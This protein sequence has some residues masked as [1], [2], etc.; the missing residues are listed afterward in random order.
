MVTSHPF[1]GYIVSFLPDDLRFRKRRRDNLARALQWWLDKTSVPI[2]ILTSNW[3]PADVTLIGLDVDLSR[4]TVVELPPQPLILNRIAALETFYSSA[5]DWGVMLDDD[6]LL[7]DGPQHNRGPRLFV[8]MA[9]NGIAAYDGID[10]FFPINPQKIGFGPIYR[11]D[12][13][14]YLNHHV[15]KRNIDLKGSMF[16]VRNF[17]KQNKKIVLPDATFTLHGE[18]RYFALEAV[19]LGYSVMRCENIVLREFGSPSHFGAN[20]TQQMKIG[21]SHL[22]TMYQAQGLSMRPGSHLHDLSAFW[23]NCW[24][25]KPT[26]VVI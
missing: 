18:D 19:K 24:G 17:R 9:S 1:G 15:F 16:V 11:D 5:H 6:A 7:Y 12:P 3:K 25:S 4:V 23:R 2:T 20:R 26:Q 8:E 22:A 14:L 21:Y 13:N 10:V